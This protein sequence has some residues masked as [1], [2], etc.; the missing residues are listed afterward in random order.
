MRARLDAMMP[1]AVAMDETFPV[2]AAQG[3]RL[4][5]VSALG[6][7]TWTAA[8]MPDWTLELAQPVAAAALAVRVVV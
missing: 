2:T 3:A 8:A 1:A 5:E 6:A 7:A 4:A